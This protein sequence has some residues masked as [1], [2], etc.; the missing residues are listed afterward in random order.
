MT[1]DERVFVAGHRGLLGRALVRALHERG[2]RDVVTADR[3]VLDLTRRAE[4]DAFF[5]RVRP[6]YV[7]VAAARVGGI[8]ANV[9]QPADLIADNLAIE[10][11][12]VDAAHRHGARGLLLFG[13]SCM[14]PRIDDRPIRADDL[15]GGPLEPTSR[16]YATAKLA[17]VALC[18]AYREQHGARFS[19]LVPATMYGPHDHF[20]TDR[21]H[22]IPAL[23]ERLFAARA[24]GDAE[25]RVLGTGAARREFV[26]C[27]D[28]ARAALLVMERGDAPDLLNVGSGEEI[29]IRTLAETLAER[30]GFRG[31][32][33]FDASQPEG[34]M[35]K[36]LDSAPIQALG[37]APS[38]DLRAGLDDAVAWYRNARMRGE[39]AA[40]SAPASGADTES[41]GG[42]PPK[43]MGET[44][45]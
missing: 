14:Y 36:V 31:A 33:R 26:H 12:V 13:S 4:V 23:I 18:R 6:S 5:A 22:V 25:L 38:V 2:A 27:D 1:S 39:A 41:P 17:G 9:R 34:A 10:L 40:P 8:V 37:F 24:R 21:A 45:R 20:G 11:N 35:R 42:R 30:V 7:F 16:A 44:A 28:A 29:T 43:P 3:S 19:V 32:L 15:Y